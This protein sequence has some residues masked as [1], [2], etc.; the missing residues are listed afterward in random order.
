MLRIFCILLICS[1]INV[2]SCGD[3]AT[4]VPHEEESTDLDGDDGSEQDG[5]I[6][7][8]E[9]IVVDDD[10]GAPG[11]PVDEEQISGDD[12]GP[13]IEKTP[14]EETD[15]GDD[16]DIVITHECPLGEELCLDH[17]TSRICVETELGRRWQD[18][19]CASGYGCLYGLCFL[20][21][22]SD[23]CRL[24]EINDSG[25]VCSLY[26]IIN[27]SWVDP[28]P[29]NS[30]S[31]RARAYNQWL[32]TKNLFHG[33]VNQVRY[34]D[35]PDYN[36]PTALYCSVDSAHWTGTF[37][38]TEALRLKATGSNAARQNIR[39]LVATLH[40]WFNISGT[41]GVL[42]RFAAP[43]DDHPLEHFGTSRMVHYNVEYEG[44]L[45]DYIGEVSRDA[46][47][48]VMLGYA[49]AYEAL[50]EADEET[51]SLIREDVV[52]LVDEL[53]TE[54]EISAVVTVDDV[55]IPIPI[56]LTARFMV[57]CPREFENGSPQLVIDTSDFSSAVMLGFQEFMPDVSLLINQVPG[58]GWVPMIPRASSAVMLAAIFRVAMLA[59]EG[60][61][62]YEAKFAEISNF[63]YN[64]SSEWGN[65]YDWVESAKFQFDFGSCG[66]HYYSNNIV[67]QP[68][69]NWARLEDNA[70]IKGQVVNDVL[71]TALWPSYVDTKN[72][73]FS[74]IYAANFGGA[75]PSVVE[76]ANDQLSQFNPPP[77]YYLGV[78]LTDDPAYL[79]HESG[80]DPPQANHDTAVDIRHRPAMNFIWQNHPW[81][82]IGKHEPNVLHPG[83]D[84][85]VAYWMA[86]YHEFLPDD[87]EGRCL[88]WRPAE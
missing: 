25:E 81:A 46:Y 17:V 83:N 6:I 22:C 45:Y 88:A 63:Y 76:I 34:A 85:M 8:D 40:F 7:D 50:G 16:Q 14:H 65:V 28:D 15:P 44:E 74:Y 13:L 32:L 79:P 87:N 64:S 80:C 82:L 18:E 37:L 35:P 20:G 57:V 27:G 78:D 43:S 39:D 60:V 68:M 75:D 9:P 70:Y 49:L 3:G 69:Y 54:R 73:F 51:R 33:G 71:D 67:M 56:S 4:L 10:D 58:L 55:T 77:R 23:S 26:D 61:P 59:T 12:G 66:S 1:L 19:V 24:G 84:Y 29:E 38:A 52:E 48:G 11:D 2:C 72:S 30:L 5:G 21:Q 41:P 42:A 86:R 31:D 36:T 47:Q 53:M 62:G